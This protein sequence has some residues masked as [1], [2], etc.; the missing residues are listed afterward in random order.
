MY[1]ITEYGD[2]CV[3][4]DSSPRFTEESLGAGSAVLSGGGT[5]P[6]PQSSATVA[7]TQ[8]IFWRVYDAMVEAIVT[9]QVNL[10]AGVYRCALCGAVSNAGDLTLPA[11]KYADLTHE[12]P[13]AS[14]YIAGGR[15]L[16]DPALT[17]VGGKQC[18]DLSDSRFYADGGDLVFRYLVVYDGGDPDKP[19][20]MMAEP[21]TG[22]T[23][24]V[25]NG[26]TYLLKGHAN[27]VF[28]MPS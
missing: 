11:A 2:Y 22:G 12:L 7:V 24:T 6:A 26:N 14:G 20:L 28:R 9:G 10:L 23:V 18:F 27:G 4:E 15:P 1:R 19:L 16:F 13:T 17:N 25:P 3:A 5:I 21:T 8:P